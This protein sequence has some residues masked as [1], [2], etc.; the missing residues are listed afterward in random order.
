MATKPVIAL[1]M[2]AA[3]CTGAL[4]GVYILKPRLLAYSAFF[5]GLLAVEVFTAVLRLKSGEGVSAD[6]IALAL[7]TGL[8]AALFALEGILVRGRKA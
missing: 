3:L 7:V 8:A 5:A 4:L 6:L 1:V 2:V